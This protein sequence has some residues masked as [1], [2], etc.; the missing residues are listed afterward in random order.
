LTKIYDEKEHEKQIQQ[1]ARKD[2]AQ[3][4]RNNIAGKIE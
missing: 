2:A 4:L 3:A 1:K